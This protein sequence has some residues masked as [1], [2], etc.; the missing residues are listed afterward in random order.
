MAEGDWRHWSYATTAGPVTTIGGTGSTI[1]PSFTAHEDDVDG[2]LGI[3][4]ADPRLYIGA[5]YLWRQNNYGYPQ[6]NGV[7][8]GAEKLP[9]LDQAITIYGSAYYYP[10][11]QGTFSCSG[12]ASGRNARISFVQVRN[13]SRL[14]LPRTVV[15]GVS[16]MSVSLE[17][18]TTTRSTH[19]RISINTGRTLDLGYTS[20]RA[21][22]R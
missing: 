3:K 7:G 22:A 1:V 9:D 18:N 14:E 11:V 20:N 6:I 16:W 5:S 13:R 4:V 8:F 10:S 19:R 12:C 15:P 17:I 2:R 21:R